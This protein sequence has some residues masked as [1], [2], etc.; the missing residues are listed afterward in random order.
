MNLKQ[1]DRGIDFATG[2]S[3]AD[4][5][6]KWGA[7]FVMRYSAGSG[8]GVAQTQWK[9]CQPGEIDA[10]TKAGYDFIALSEWYGSRVETGIANGM[11]DGKADLV[12]WKNRG[13][14][15]GASIYVSWDASQPN[16]SAMHYV[17]DYLR[18]YQ[19][20]LGDYYHVDLYAG[21]IALH[22]AM[23]AG[24]IRYGMRAMAD[25]WSGDGAWYMPGEGWLLKAQSL[26]LTSPAH[27]V[28]NGNRWYNGKAD[29]DVVLRE[30]VG[31]FF[32]VTQPIATPNPPAVVVPVTW[33][34][35]T[36]V[37]GE[38]LTDIAGIYHVT[39]EQLEKDNPH[40][41][42]PVGN[43]NDIWPND[44]IL[45]RLSPDH[46]A[47]PPVNVSPGMFHPIMPGDTL[48]HIAQGWGVTLKA[49]EDA[50]PQLFAKSGSWDL[51]YPGET[52][53]HP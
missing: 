12:F 28:Q 14:P 29:E 47:L 30:L 25:S 51:I 37:A 7:K 45:V 20:S 35:H 22:V 36:V 40:A 21:D 17:L 4:T 53:R 46:A 49:V 6:N 42:H 2:V 26:L 23:N 44:Q 31:S 41:G 16:P 34:W 10:W 43:F 50:N 19:Q 8:N 24:L 13:L 32:D 33:Y 3:I 11:A 39:L 52:V 38:N 18:G 9:L 5:P 1:F 48:E 15:Q 27:L